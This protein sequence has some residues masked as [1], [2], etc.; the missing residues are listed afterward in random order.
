M[1]G[2]KNGFPF[3]SKEIKTMIM[4]QRKRLQGKDFKGH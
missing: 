3:S 4:I 2:N 1:Q